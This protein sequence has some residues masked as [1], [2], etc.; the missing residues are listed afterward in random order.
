M[1]AGPRAPAAARTQGTAP[2]FPKGLWHKWPEQS[3]SAQLCQRSPA[4][5]LQS[6]CKTITI[7][8]GFKTWSAII[9]YLKRSLDLHQLLFFTFSSTPS[10]HHHPPHCSVKLHLNSQKKINSWDFFLKSSRNNWLLNSA[11]QAYN[12]K[13]CFGLTG[14][15]TVFSW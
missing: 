1:A 13:K 15:E 14:N 5:E 11:Q 3:S 10:W 4:P 9:P 7:Q 12:Y 8:G 2:S 6:C